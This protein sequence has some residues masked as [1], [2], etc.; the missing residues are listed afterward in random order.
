[1]KMN[2]V[3]CLGTIALGLTCLAAPLRAADTA[4]LRVLILSGQ[5]NHDWR[6]TTPALQKILTASGQFTA[7]ITEHPETCTTETFAK[8]DAVLS[9]WNAFGKGGVTAWPQP[10]K[11]ALLNFVRAGHGFVVVHAGSS[12]FYDWPEYQQLAGA[13]WA[14][15]QTNHHAPHT[16]TVTPTTVDHPITR[17]VA[18]F[19]TTDE[20]WQKP[21]THPQAVVLATAEDHPS[22]LVTA[23]GNGRGFTILLGHDA[24]FMENPGFQTLLLR[25][26][27][28]AATGQ[29][30]IAPLAGVAAPPP[31]PPSPL[32]WQKTGD[33]LTLLNQDH[34][35]WQFNCKPAEGKP[36]FHP[37]ALADGTVL[38]ALRPKDHPWH[39]GLWWSWKFINGLNY[40][41]EDR[42]TGQSQGQTELTN[43]ATVPNAD[44]SADMALQL[45]YHPPGA[46][47]LLKELRTITISAPAADGSYYINW[48]ATF[49][50]L[51]KDL[52]LE[53]T[54]LASEPNGRPFGG[55][56]GLSLRLAPTLKSGTF[57]NS[58]NATGVADT[59]GKPARWLDCSGADLAS[60]AGGVAV[61]D[62]P[63]NLHHPVSW[64]VDQNMPFMEPAPLFHAPL[65]LGAGQTLSMRY[66]LWI[67]PGTVTAETLEKEW[68]RYAKE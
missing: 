57:T 37:L 68:T 39:R 15:G 61:F 19:T 42:Q 41:E 1:M 40:W 28:W 26:T 55:Y 4:P 45:A 65:K 29:V 18:P 51:D 46:A 36:Y 44:G 38:T 59:H 17:G 32:H 23:L 14:N 50:A 52:A 2:W 25:G 30:T 34:V 49:T 47:P 9:N 21:G 8:Y 5:N 3:E 58:Q 22:V 13:S 7:D 48:A 66:R 11:D 12:S 35:V 31:P 27:Q 64:F 67:H 6:H 33:T 24:K 63:S 60:K 10:T 62:H 56:A 43:A 20:L 16:F 53:R 54:P